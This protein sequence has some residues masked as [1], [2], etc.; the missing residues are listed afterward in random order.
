[1]NRV[2]E[3]CCGLDVHKAS[4]TACVRVPDESGAPHRYEIGEFAATTQGLLQLR[5]WLSSFEVELVWAWRPPVSIGS[6][7]T[8]C[9]KTTS[10]CGFS[11]PGT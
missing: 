2:V 5:D 8:I 7:S 6:L 3:R 1:M 4:V 11:T 9:S 10:S